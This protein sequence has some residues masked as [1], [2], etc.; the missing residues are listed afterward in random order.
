MLSGVEGRSAVSASLSWRSRRPPWSRA[1]DRDG[2]AGADRATS[3][4]LCIGHHPQ[5]FVWYTSSCTGHDEPELDPLSNQRRLGAGPDLD[6][7][8]CRPTARRRSTASGRR[9][10]SAAPSPTRT[11]S[12]ARRSSS[13][14]SIPTASSRAAPRAAASTSSRRPATTSSVRRSGRSRSM[15][16]PSRRRST[17]RCSTRRPASRS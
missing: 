12:T 15:A 10:G 3:Q 2:T 13:S 17:P 8:A 5:D 11:A 7:R 14:S 4:S 1:G 16:T 6:D 9:S